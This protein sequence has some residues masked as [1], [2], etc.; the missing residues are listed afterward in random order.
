MLIND[1]IAYL[2]GALHDG[3]YNKF[4]NSFRFTQNNLEWLKILQKMLSE[5][6]YKSWTYKEGRNRNVYAL[7]TT[8]KCLSTKF[9]VNLLK[10]DSQK[11]GLM[12]KLG[13]FSKI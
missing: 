12:A 8:A 1:T 9:D 6:D 7:E 10:T 2:N 3:T 5:L 13:W 4:H 11:I